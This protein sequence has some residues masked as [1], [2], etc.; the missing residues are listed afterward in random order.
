MATEARETTFMRYVCSFKVPNRGIECATGKR[1]C[2]GMC[3]L[4][5]AGAGMPVVTFSGFLRDR[6]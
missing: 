1:D 5:T 3:P 6:A 2:K 4:P